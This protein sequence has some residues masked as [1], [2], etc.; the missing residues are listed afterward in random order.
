MINVTNIEK[1]ATHDGPGIR[2]VIFLKGCPLYCPWCANPETQT[3]KPTL[4]HDVRKCTSCQMCASV[5]PAK[6]ISFVDNKFTYDETKC[7]H[8]F[9][10]EKT[11]LN[12]VI[13]FYGKGMTLDEI[14]VEVLKDKEY[15][16]NSNGGITVSG[17][18]PFVQF[19]NLLS[20]LK[21]AK[22][23]GLHT[24][25]ET[26]GNYSLDKL[27]EAL[28]YID[29]FL[30]DFK[31]IDDQ[32]L[33]DVT[34]GNGLLI[35]ENLMYLLKHFSEKVIVRMPMIPTFN[36]DEESV[37]KAIDYVKQ[38]GALEVNLLPYHSLGKVKYEKMG[39]TYELPVK[40]MDKKE[41]EVYH[42]YALSLGLKSKIGG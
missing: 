9:T 34:G 15:Y 7:I 38:L 19:N 30:Y 17:G 4:M 5:C 2:S 24:A 3:M 37:Y 12:D 22:E 20:I 27:K 28:P 36:F 13:T 11:C 21:R 6:A 32:I 14:F 41:L 39:L 16:D 40:M 35:K 33:K 42:N 1:F 29:L 23:E 10:C 31:H 26:T 25:V 8:C 18:E